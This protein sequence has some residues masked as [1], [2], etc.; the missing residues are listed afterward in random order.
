MTGNDTRSE[1]PR[2]TGGDPPRALRSVA[3]PPQRDPVADWSP[4]VLPVGPAESVEASSL[5]P[6]GVAVLT[7]VTD[8]V[9][10]ALT[11]GSLSIVSLRPTVVTFALHSA[12]PMQ[13]V[14]ARAHGFGLSLLADHQEFTA[15]YFASPNRPAGADQ[16]ARMPFRAGPV[17]GAPLLAE[18]LGWLDCTIA[19]V[20][21]AGGQ[22]VVVGNVGY[23]V[24]APDSTEIG[25][26]VRSTPLLRGGGRTHQ[27]KNPGAPWRPPPVRGGGPSAGA[28]AGLSRSVSATRMTRP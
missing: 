23:D 26:P 16:F 8:G 24:A 20:V 4:P 21:P 2:S 19:A 10:S 5:L 7:A 13:Q 28:A 15:R 12:G 3:S 22:L 6:R 9:P 17:S 1:G 27:A 11:I 18:A 25:A 14:L